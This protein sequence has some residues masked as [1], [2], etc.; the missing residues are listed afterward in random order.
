M[1]PTIANAE[2]LERRERAL[3]EAHRRGLDAVLV[4]GRGGSFDAFAD[5]L[6]FSNH[7]SPMV[8][9]PPIEGVLTGCE[10]AALLV[11]AGGSTLIASDFVAPG[12]QIERV[13]RAWDLIGEVVAELRE[14]GAAR[15]RVGVIGQEVLPMAAVVAIQDALPGLRLEPADDISS[16]LRLRLSATEIDLLARA[17]AV[18]RDIYRVFVEHVREGALEGEAVGAALRFAAQVPGCMHWNF[19]SSSGEHA[20]SLVRHSLPAWDP[21][22]AFAGGDV[23]HA[24]CFGYVDGYCYDLART[25]VLDGPEV[26][27]KRDVARRTHEAVDEVAAA[28]EPGVTCRRLVAIGSR[29][30]ERRGLS[31]ALGS[32]GH[33]LGAGFFRLYLVAA[34]P[35]LELELEPPCG[36]SIEIFATDENG[37]FAYH[38]DNYVVLES[39]TVCLTADA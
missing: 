19:I 34:G 8:W 28:L 5:V 14:R 37:R 3:E 24:D 38:E 27:A 17:G 33:G 36:I 4:W 10:H 20:G 30:L 26:D 7:Y 29:A 12:A 39:E 23:V 13:R 1:R 18:G 35:D 6:Y 15:W 25:V 32:F 2:F 31:A 22:Q 9:V 11:A 21:E 16:G